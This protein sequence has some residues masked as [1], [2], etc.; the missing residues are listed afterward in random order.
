[1]RSQTGHGYS[2][3]CRSFNRVDVSQHASH[4]SGSAH[5]HRKGPHSMLSVDAI[6]VQ[7]F[8]DRFAVRNVDSGESCEV[9][10]DQTSVSPRMLIADF[11][12]AQHQLKEAVKAVR[13]GLRSPEILM[14]PMERIEGGVTQVEYRVFVELGMGAGGSKVGVH[15]GLPVSGDAVRKAIQDYKHHGA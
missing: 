11:T 3:V 10:R 4:G 9:Q 15:T 12:M 6:Y 14:H 7:V 8:A 13:R 5:V 2:F 1:M